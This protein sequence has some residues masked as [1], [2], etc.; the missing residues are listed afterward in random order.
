MSVE[1]EELEDKYIDE[2]LYDMSDAEL[3]AA[4]KAAKRGEASTV[5]E[6]TVA[7]DGAT[8]EVDGTDEV[9][10][11][12]NETEEVE[13]T[14]QSAESD[15]DDNGEKTEVV[16]GTEDSEEQPKA[17][18]QA[19]EEAPVVQKRKY[20]ANGREFEFTDA[21]IFEQF[22]KVF[23]Q[24]MNYTQKMQQMAPYKSLV[25][26]M[27]EQNLTQ[28]DLNLAIEV[29]KGDKQAIAE[30]MRRTGTDALDL[31]TE[32]KQEYRPKN[33]GRNEAELAIQEIVEE[34]GK[35][36]EYP[37]TYHVVEKQWDD[38]SR[39]A[40]ASNPELI[41]ELHLDVKSGVFDKVSPV[42]M[43]MKVLDGGRKSD[44]EYYIAAGQQYYAETNKVAAE[45]AELM[46][47][48]AE[49]VA[50]REKVKQL[51][52]EAERARLAKAKAEQ[53]KRSEAEKAAVKRK[54]AAPTA[55]R[56]GTK[57]PIDFLDSDESFE[58]WYR[59]K[60]TNKM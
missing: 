56:A 54:A 12:D 24:A 10:V 20:K 57:E 27:K 55:S 18:E 53:A 48:Q 35:D 46:K 13:T 33:Y 30:V 8:E 29:L 14:E 6:E 31:D 7:D 38:K 11:D 19:K 26:T 60:I 28:E 17:D 43:K 36:P 41:K 50:N 52:A 16:E 2:D 49:L 5:V 25:A 21:E 40:F 9:E 23:G 39:Q 45:N 42:A 47:R 32:A 59:E 44:I 58:N 34:I 4:F 1:V 3:E 22:G 37:V 51:E 15:S